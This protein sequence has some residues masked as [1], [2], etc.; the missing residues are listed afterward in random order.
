MAG[1]SN[2][3]AAREAANRPRSIRGTRRHGSGLADQKGGL[4][5]PEIKRLAGLSNGQIEGDEAIRTLLRD[6]A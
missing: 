4:W 1:K 5:Q 2:A 3:E 6:Y